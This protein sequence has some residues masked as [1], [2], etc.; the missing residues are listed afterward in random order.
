MASTSCPSS[1]VVLNALCDVIEDSS[2][3]TGSNEASDALEAAKRVKEWCESQGNGPALSVF[4][5]ELV[6]DLQRTFSAPTGR[7]PLNR[8]KMWKAMFSLRSSTAFVTRWVSFLQH[9]GAVPTPILYQHLT[10]VVL[11]MLIHS[12]YKIPAMQQS[13]LTPELSSN[14][15]NTLRYA[16]GYVIR[17]IC[18]KIGK[19][20]D[21]LKDDLI[22]CC[23]KLV[24]EAYDPSDPS[25]CE[26]WTDLVDRGGLWHIRETTFQLLCALEEEI[27]TY[28]DALSS[29][30]AADLRTQF[31][32]KLLRVILLV[33]H[34]GRLRSG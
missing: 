29:P 7:L 30:N 27:R 11:R 25:T 22:S 1:S 28:L 13:R 8:E 16:A 14:E 21:S 6:S 9:S 19:I 10:D 20:T 26:E 32:E 18:K 3:S 24:K 5:R 33:H 17:H 31:V 15:G 34:Y 23:R 12:H 4:S 2:F